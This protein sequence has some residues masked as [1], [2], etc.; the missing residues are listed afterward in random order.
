MKTE[1]SE[2]YHMEKWEAR[3]QDA[4]QRLPGWHFERY[5]NS[6]ERIAAFPPNGVGFNAWCE[7]EN[8]YPVNAVCGPFYVI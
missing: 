1:Y 5:G 4:K 7:L 3:L 2:F 6:S 8:Y